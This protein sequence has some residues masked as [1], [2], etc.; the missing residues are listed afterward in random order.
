MLYAAWSLVPCP[1]GTAAATATTAAAA[2]AAAADAAAAA[3]AAQVRSQGLIHLDT[4]TLRQS[5][6]HTLRA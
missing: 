6:T 3:A 4:Q 2:D 1:N 5:D